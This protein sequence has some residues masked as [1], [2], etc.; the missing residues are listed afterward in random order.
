M[1]YK[2]SQRFAVYLVKPKYLTQSNIL[3]SNKAFNFNLYKYPF[4]G[5][6]FNI[7]LD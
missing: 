2:A 6:F 4:T 3:S 7:Y 1:A 5:L